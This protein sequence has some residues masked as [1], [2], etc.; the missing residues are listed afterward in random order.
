MSAPRRLSGLQSDVLSLYRLL[1]R[2]ARTRD[3]DKEKGL[4]RLVATQFRR[5]ALDI[6]R[7][8]YQ[9]IE[10]WLRYGHKQAKLL[11]RSGFSTAFE[12]S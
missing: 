1:L 3:P 5:K 4:Q 9:Q 2:K 11:D 8:D 6:A 12:S 10:H 7:S